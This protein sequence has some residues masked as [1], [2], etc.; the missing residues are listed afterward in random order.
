MSEAKHE[1]AFVWDGQ[2][3]LPCVIH[4]DAR[5]TLNELLKLML[6]RSFRVEVSGHRGKSDRP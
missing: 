2:Q 3:L 5:H 4:N 1:H 6:D